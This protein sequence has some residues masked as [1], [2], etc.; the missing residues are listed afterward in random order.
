MQA[1]LDLLILRM[2]TL[3]RANQTGSQE[4]LLVEHGSLYPALQRLEQQ[5]QAGPND[6][7]IAGE[8][9]ANLSQG[10]LLSF[11]YLVASA[12]LFAGIAGG[13]LTAFNMRFGIP[14]LARKLCKTIL[15]AAWRKS[16]AY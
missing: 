1:T 6:A 12:L 16:L 10:E 14:I 2:L 4:E 15:I 11:L 3:A 13:I 8:Q 9:D 5:T 7:V